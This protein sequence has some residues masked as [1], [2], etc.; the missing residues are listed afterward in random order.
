MKNALLVTTC[1]LTLLAVPA[2]GQTS[3]GATG[4]AEVPAGA[5]AGPLASEQTPPV[6]GGASSTHETATEPGAGAT[7]AGVSSAGST[8]TEGSG[9]SSGSKADQSG[10]SAGDETTVSTGKAGTGG[11]NLDQQKRSEV[12]RS[13]NKTGVKRITTDVDVSIG[14][15]VPSSVQLH[16]LPVD[17]VTIVPQYR[18]YRYFVLADGRIVIVDPDT[19]MV[20]TVLES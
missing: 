20:V 17:V 4:G 7:G 12:S 5:P 11:A 19:L 6:E 2:Y 13:F 9:R 1:A 3:S 16:V 14:V 10:K 8:T 15:A 18:G